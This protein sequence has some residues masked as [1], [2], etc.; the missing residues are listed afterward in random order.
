M[1]SFTFILD[2]MPV[3]AQTLLHYFFYINS[4]CLPDSCI[5]FVFWS[6]SKL[7]LSPGP[8]DSS[9][10]RQQLHDRDA[11]GFKA[12]NTGL[13]PTQPHGPSA[14]C[15]VGNMHHIILI[16]ANVLESSG[17]TVMQVLFSHHYCLP[18]KHNKPVACYGYY[19]SRLFCV[20]I[21]A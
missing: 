18:W 11:W 17:A 1:R 19:E 3:Y 4:L 12:P 10:Y 14:R 6:F 21:R 16:N 15:Q 8:S 13:H 5:S 20:M 7:G 2:G 9:V